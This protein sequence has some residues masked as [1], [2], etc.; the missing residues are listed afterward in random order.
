[1]PIPAKFVAMNVD[2]NW[3][4]AISSA[5]LLGVSAGLLAVDIRRHRREGRMEADIEQLHVLQTGLLGDVDRLTARVASMSNQNDRVSAL[6]KSNA[7]DVA[8][9]ESAEIEL[10]D[11]WLL[12]EPRERTTVT[13]PPRSTMVGQIVVSGE[14]PRTPRNVPCVCGSGRKFKLCH[15]QAL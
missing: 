12:E 14:W 15:G 1:M 11:G 3:V 6:Q 9:T 7:P 4:T 2:P 8:G 5:G 10:L 13:T